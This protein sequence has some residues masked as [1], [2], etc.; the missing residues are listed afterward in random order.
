MPRNL[1]QIVFSQAVKLCDGSEKTKKFFK[2]MS[3]EE[4][5]AYVATAV[6]CK[7]FM[8][9]ESVTAV[10][11]PRWFGNNRMTTDWVRSSTL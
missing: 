1:V 7:E 11:V 5:R 8:R 9:P 3:E 10:E 6:A 4:K 2:S